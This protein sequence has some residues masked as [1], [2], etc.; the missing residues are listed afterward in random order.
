M[1]A[2]TYKPVEHHHVTPY[3]CVDDSRAAIQWYGEVFG[4]VL[5]HEP[6]LMDDGRVGHCE[7]RIGDTTFQMADAFPEIGVV[8]PTRSAS[9]VA[10]TVYVEDADATYALAVERGAVGLAAPADQFYGARAGTI[11]DPFAHRWTVTT[12]LGTRET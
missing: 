11:S 9:G 10:F 12:W 6:I 5:T 3:L 2:T 4:A 8:P 1:P 7:L